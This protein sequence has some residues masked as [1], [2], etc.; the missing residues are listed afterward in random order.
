MEENGESRGK[1]LWVRVCVSKNVH[2]G[3]TKVR[4]ERNILIA[5]VDKS[6][7]SFIVKQRSTIAL[8]RPLPPLSVDQVQWLAFYDSTH[9]H[10]VLS[11]VQNKFIWLSSLSSLTA[12]FTFTGRSRIQLGTYHSRTSRCRKEERGT[13]PSPEDGDFIRYSLS[14]EVSI[15]HAWLYVWVLLSVWL[16]I[17]IFW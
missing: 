7:T 4:E 14:F 15:W 16:C 9:A 3:F 2:L 6:F 13:F 5:V 12:N 17:S 10:P 11:F 8:L 1:W